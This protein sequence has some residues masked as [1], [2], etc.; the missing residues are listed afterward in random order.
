MVVVEL[1]LDEVVLVVEVELVLVEVVLVVE[2][3]V[4]VDPPAPPPPHVTSRPQ[5]EESW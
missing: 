4:L 3:V 2:L 5:S 1:V